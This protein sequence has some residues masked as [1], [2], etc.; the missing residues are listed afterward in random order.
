M[1]TAQ[2]RDIGLRRP[3]DGA[4]PAA[5]HAGVQRALRAGPHRQVCLHA[6]HPFAQVILAPV[7]QFSRNSAA[8]QPRLSRNSVAIQQRFG[9]LPRGTARVGLTTGLAGAA[10]AVGAR[11]VRRLERCAVCLSRAWAR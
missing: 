7:P 11:A 1:F 10:A 4:A 2:T 5:A 9:M 6:S 8:P 3:A